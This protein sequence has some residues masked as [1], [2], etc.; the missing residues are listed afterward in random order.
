MV[1]GSPRPD[2]Q[3]LKLLQPFLRTD[4]EKIH[5]SLP[6]RSGRQSYGMETGQ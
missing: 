1:R 6:V 5:V 4:N 3:L 2:R